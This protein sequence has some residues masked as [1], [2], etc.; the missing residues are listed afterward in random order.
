[1]TGIGSETKEDREG[2]TR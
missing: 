2:K 1:M